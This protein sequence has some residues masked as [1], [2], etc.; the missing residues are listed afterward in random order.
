MN[1]GPAGIPELLQRAFRNL[2]PALFSTSTQFLGKQ[3]HF[4]QDELQI[5]PALNRSLGHRHCR[6]DRLVVDAHTLAMKMLKVIKIK[7]MVE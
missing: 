6:S 2:G 5:T 1:T 7:E 3:L 4:T